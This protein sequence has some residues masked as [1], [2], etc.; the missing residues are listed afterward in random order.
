MRAQKKT[1]WTREQNTK[2][3]E[4]PKITDAVTVSST[5][6]HQLEKGKGNGGLPQIVGKNKTKT[7]K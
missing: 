2:Q 7:K 1:K 3:F 5:S 4:S 6:F